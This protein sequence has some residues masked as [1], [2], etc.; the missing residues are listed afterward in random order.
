M[1]YVLL[2]KKIR[3]RR[4][5]KAAAKGQQ[6]GQHDGTMGQEPTP[7]ERDN[8]TRIERV[9]RKNEE[10]IAHVLKDIKQ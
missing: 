3:D 9:V 10:R 8:T 1:V 5:R 4:A 6:N 2:A 7:K